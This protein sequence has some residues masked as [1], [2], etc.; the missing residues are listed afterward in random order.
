MPPILS[1]ILSSHQ[2]L[3]DDIFRF[4]M[5][6]DN[7]LVLDFSE[8]NTLLTDA[9]IKNTQQQEAYI[10]DQLTAA[11]ALVGVGGYN[12]ERVLYRRSTLFTDAKENRNVHLGIDLWTTAGTPIKTPL[13]GYVHHIKNNKGFG[14]FGPTIIL[15][16]VLDDTVFFTLYGHLS[17][18]SLSNKKTGDFIPKGTPFCKIG[19]Y[20][21]NGDW[22]PH[23]HF[24]VIAD[25]L[26][27]EGDFAGVC[28]LT[29]QKRF[30]ALCPNP[31]LILKIP[32]LP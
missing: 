8:K 13:D 32:T 29:D 10:L 1:S 7:T 24:Q 26:D 20:P 9:I 15:K 6:A 27:Y 30:L 19:N 18:D 5:Q 3:F 4:K 23:L 2:Y 16:H 31:N 11:D 22:A 14:N 21:V 25:M 28:S 17:M 12:E